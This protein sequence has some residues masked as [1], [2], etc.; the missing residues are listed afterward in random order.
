MN[1]VAYGDS[2]LRS[3]SDLLQG[4]TEPPNKIKRIH[5]IGISN[6][7]RGFP[8]DNVG[9]NKQAIELSVPQS[10][11]VTRLYEFYTKLED[12]FGK[13]GDY[14]FISCTHRTISR[15]TTFTVKL[16]PEK[17]GDFL[18]DVRNIPEVHEVMEE[19]EGGYVFPN[20][21]QRFYIILAS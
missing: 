12:T 17:L 11:D 21:S 10:T 16:T 20:Q 6:L 15:G 1:N 4:N 18:D 9:F 14:G 19:S 8:A 13:H 3:A 7:K 2:G 5:D